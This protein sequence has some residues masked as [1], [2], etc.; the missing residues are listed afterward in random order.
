MKCYFCDT[1][2]KRDKENT[3]GNGF[4]GV[5]NKDVHLSCPSC[6]AEFT[7]KK[8]ENISFKD[9]IRGK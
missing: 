9:M 7:G 1:E 8:T 4:D 2:L 5:C 6:K 3:Y